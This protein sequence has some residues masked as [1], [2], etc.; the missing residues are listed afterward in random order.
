MSLLPVGQWLTGRKVSRIYMRVDKTLLRY[1]SSGTKKG[2]KGRT[3]NTNNVLSI[4]TPFY[5]FGA[6]SYVRQVELDLSGVPAPENPKWLLR[7][8]R[9]PALEHLEVTVDCSHRQTQD[10]AYGK[11][12]EVLYQH[13]LEFPVPA[14]KKLSFVFRPKLKAG[15]HIGSYVLGDM[16]IQAALITAHGCKSFAYM[17]QAGSRSSLG[18]SEESESCDSSIAGSVLRT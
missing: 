13:G 16:H 7:I 2:V 8:L 10:Q 3:R 11:E 6:L 17:V 15:H 4:S 9:Y 14:M 12:K 18:T 1:R 5:S